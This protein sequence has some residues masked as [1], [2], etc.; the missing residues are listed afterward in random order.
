MPALREGSEVPSPACRRRRH[1]N[2]GTIL[3]AALFGGYQA[4]NTRARVKGLAHLSSFFH[5]FFRFLFYIFSFP[6]LVV[7]YFF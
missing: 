2:S 5:L 4:P 7:L 6:F 1:G 3:H